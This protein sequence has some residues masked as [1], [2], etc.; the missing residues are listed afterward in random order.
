MLASES[1]NS[2]RRLS[3]EPRERST[4]QTASHDIW[5]Q[6]AEAAVRFHCSWL[7]PIRARVGGNN[8][9]VSRWNFPKDRSLAA[10]TNPLNSKHINQP[11]LT[12][13]MFTSSETCKYVSVP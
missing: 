6:N 13:K 3:V 4:W 10:S 9:W 7:C 2:A 8:A 12:Y 5:W 11:R 1:I